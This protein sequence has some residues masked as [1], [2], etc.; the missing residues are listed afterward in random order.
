MRHTFHRVCCC[1]GSIQFLYGAGEPRA[2]KW[3]RVLYDVSHVISWPLRQIKCGLKRTVIFIDFPVTDARECLEIAKN[4]LAIHRTLKSV[5]SVGFFYSVETFSPRVF[6]RCVIV[7]VAN[8]FRFM[9]RV[10]QFNFAFEKSV[11]FLLL[12]WHVEHFVSICLSAHKQV[13]VFLYDPT[14]L[15][16]RFRECCFCSHREI[17]QT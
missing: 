4:W 11:Q 7:G 16:L 6:I 12:A 9:L 8:G 10:L 17:F 5:E 1:C 14:S 15:I 13:C 3:F 2:N